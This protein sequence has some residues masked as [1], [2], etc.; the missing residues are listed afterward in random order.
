MLCEKCGANQANLHVSQSINGKKSDLYVC[1]NCAAEMGYLGAK[2]IFN[3]DFF[4]LLSPHIGGA[5]ASPHISGSCP[6]CSESLEQY[7]STR[8]FG[9]LHCYSYFNFVE[10]I[11]KKVHGDT[12]HIGKL[13]K[14][15]DSN[16]KKRR[17]IDSLKKKLEEAIANEEFEKAAGFRDQIREMEGLT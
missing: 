17:E 5:T 7:K 16:L 9:C 15:A 3:T 1:N 4:N 10:P 14:K 13:P 2:S 6:V 12:H 8:R 11:L